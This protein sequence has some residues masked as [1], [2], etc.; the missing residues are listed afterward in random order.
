MM[1]LE[2]STVYECPRC[3]GFFEAFT[4]AKMLGCPYCGARYTVTPDKGQK[5]TENVF[6][7]A[8]VSKRIQK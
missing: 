6:K 7:V 1:P 5:Q 3:G 4:F 2:L 8:A